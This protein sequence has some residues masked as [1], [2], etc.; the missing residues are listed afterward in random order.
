MKITWYGHA[1]FKIE[2]KGY[3]IAIDPYTGVP[4]YPELNIT[5]DAVFA[6]HGHYDHNYFDAVKLNNDGKASSLNV[7]TI[8][9][10]HD[11]KQGA[12]RGSNLITV[13]ECKECG[14][15]VVHMGDIGHMLDEKQAA[16]IKGCDVLMI[17]VGGFYT[18]D[19]DAAFELVKKINPTVI[20]P[21]HYRDDRKGIGN[22]GTVDPFL[23]KFP[24]AMINHYPDH[25]FELNKST[26]PQVAVME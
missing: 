19:A 20:I 24:D 15:K 7:S 9:C 16:Q 21:M 3:E 12:L 4:G 2:N 22:I 25:T 5:A 11:E 14:A 6:S 13:F 23:A 17:P 26:Q 8:P 10:F 1:C 18:I